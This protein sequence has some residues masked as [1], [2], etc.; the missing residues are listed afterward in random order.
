MRMVKENYN[1]GFSGGKKSYAK[2]IAAN[3]PVSWKFSLEICREIK[4]KPLGKAKSFLERVISHDQWL[5][6]RR[7]TKDM[8]HR[9]G[10]PT[11]HTKTGRFP[12]RCCR[13]WVKLLEQVKANADYKGLD[14]EKLVVVH[15][16]ASQGVGRQSHQSQGRIGGKTRK[17][18]AAHL[19]V[20]VAE[21]A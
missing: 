2:A 3:A 18:K 11:S 7:Y 14:A 15:A 19:E 9:R 16:V 4:G 8:A 1:F 20:V 17:K 12:E 6:L 13:A 5:P 21:R 10:T